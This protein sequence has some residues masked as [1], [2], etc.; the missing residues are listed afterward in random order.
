VTLPPDPPKYPSWKALLSP[1]VKGEEGWRPYALSR[2][3]KA[4][5]KPELVGQ[6]TAGLERAVKRFQTNHDLAADG[7]AGPVTQGTILLLASKAADE[8]A[9]LPGGTTYG[10]AVY[11]GGGVLAATN[12]D[13]PGGVDCGP[14]QRRLGGPPFSGALLRSAF[15]PYVGL[16]WAAVLLRGR[17]DSYLERRPQLGRRGALR[18][19]V[20]AHNWPAGAEQIVRN[21]QVTSP[22][23]A[24]DWTYNPNTGQPYTR[25]EWA[26][27]YPDRILKFSLGG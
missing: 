26:E 4:R 7:V 14:A 5:Q 23:K 6:F 3:V 22:D 20:L 27:V 21:G 1:I 16:K 9:A 17:R 2:G 8:A 12:W 13:V 15:D 25:G 10:F 11:E 19:A 18:T 24:A